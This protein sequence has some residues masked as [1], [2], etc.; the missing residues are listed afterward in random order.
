MRRELAI[1][2]AKRAC[3]NRRRSLAGC[4]ESEQPIPADHE[5]FVYLETQDYNEFLAIREDIFLRI[6][7]IIEA[8]GAYFAYPSQTLYLGKDAGRDLE[9][10]KAA[11]ET[12]K[13]WREANELFMPGLSPNK[14]A[15]LEDTLRILDAACRV[16]AS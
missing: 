6:M 5:V 7:D 8:S 15:E 2:D 14:I 10:S 1:R 9:K 4:F 16:V 13:S 11:E 12:L 3:C